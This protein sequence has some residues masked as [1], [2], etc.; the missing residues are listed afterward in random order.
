MPKPLADLIA[1]L[2]LSPQ[3][4]AVLG[5]GIG[6]MLLLL[7]LAR[8]LS[9][10]DPVLRRMQAMRA[11]GTAAQG[12]LLKPA[13]A[14]PTG[15]FRAFVPQD[16]DERTEVRRTLGLAGYSGPNAVRN[17]YLL[18]LALAL[19]GPLAVAGIVL[20]RQGPG[21]PAPVEGLV[22]GLSRL[23]VLQILAVT[24]AAGFYG[25]G[26]WLKGRMK[27]RMQRIT[28]GFPNALDLL[29]ISAAAGMGF[30][31]A[32]QRVGRELA[33]VAPEI[34][35]EFL[36]TQHEILA[37]RSRDAALADMAARMGIDEAGAFVNVIV[38]SMQFGTS[39]SDALTAYATEMRENRE[40]RAQER[41]N[42][43]PVQ[44]SAVMAVLMLPA[45]ILITLGPIVIRY[46]N[47][48]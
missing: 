3:A 6:A 39:I 33:T 47:I 20:L 27:D 38:Q 18:R 12:G 36:L 26:L 43:L 44:M 40:L 42:K 23:N 1:T 14:A 21:L 19:V 13:E 45:L 8:A 10:E 15:L 48:Y 41:A 24:V 31:A 5:V 7:G 11:R 17:F 25:P 35:E 30:D 34:S 22:A 37:G 9:E 32:M 29:Q 2:T 4:L 28:D 16:R 46:L